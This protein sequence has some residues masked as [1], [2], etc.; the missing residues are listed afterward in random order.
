MPDLSAGKQAMRFDF[1]LLMAAG[2]TSLAEIARIDRTDDGAVD[3][4]DIDPR[5]TKGRF[6]LLVW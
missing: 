6:L 3:V 5:R 2:N 4:T 1:P